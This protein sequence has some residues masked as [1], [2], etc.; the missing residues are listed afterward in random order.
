ML[1]QRLKLILLIIGLLGLNYTSY[2][3]SVAVST[4][5]SLEPSNL[6]WYN[7]D[8]EIDN[9]EGV[10]VYKAYNDLINNR[11][12]NKKI[13]V[14]VIDSGFD[15]D[16]PDLKGRVW[17]NENEI[18]DNGI[19]DDD[20]GYIDDIHGWNFIGNSD[21]EKIMYE[22]YEEVRLYRKYY[23]L[24]KEILNDKQ[25]P[26]SL[27]KE[28]KT[29]L[30]C[31]EFYDSKIAKHKSIRR[32]MARFGKNY[33]TSLKILVKFYGKKK[34]TKKNI[35]NINPENKDVANAKKFILNCYKKGMNW[36]KFLRAK[37]ENDIM[38]DKH[39]NIDF[40]PRDIID[41]NPFDITDINYG[42]N[43]V[44]DLSFHGTFVSAIICANKGNNLGIDGI[45]DDVNI[46]VLRAISKGDEYDKDVALA[47]RYAVNNG[48]NIIN[49]SFGKRFSPQKEFVDAALVYAA[50]N[51]VLI[52]QGAGNE[53]TDLNKKTFYPTDKLDNG[54]TLNNYL[55]VGATSKIANLNFCGSFTNYSK[56][57]VDMFAPGVDI[58]SLYPNAKYYMG[59]GT[60][61][62]APV[63]SGVAALVWSYFPKLKACE[64]KNI[65]LNSCRHYS[66][67]KVLKP[68]KNAKRPK[69]VKFKLLSK[70]GG[71]VNAYNALKLAS[72]IYREKGLVT[73]F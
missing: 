63:V 52:V 37:N 38:L 61:F 3:Q 48:A 35:E 29:Y 25:V 34:F 2:S 72:K 62:S 53:A 36:K 46:M 14:A 33:L 19:D 7:M 6:N 49:M 55:K 66:R 9:I 69:K 27:K 1:D 54:K 12:P 24:F 71:V 15:F 73:P 30:E 39:L 60:S 18:P 13:I 32:S 56:K 70:T 50:K 64:L 58:I 68:N 65:L 47:I 57:Y 26:D 21:G 41:D 16:H 17:I 44:Y 5:D 10:S 20:N 8:A 45:T 42:N 28:Y 51:N 11:K 31:K 43:D 67:L 4:V 59:N 22:T 23:P 40:N